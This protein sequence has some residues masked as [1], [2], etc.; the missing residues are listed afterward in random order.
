MYVQ[1]EEFNKVVDTVKQQTKSDRIT[2]IACT[3]PR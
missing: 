2:S 1:I 3:Q